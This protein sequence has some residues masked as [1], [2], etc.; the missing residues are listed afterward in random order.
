MAEIP[1]FMTKVDENTP[2]EVV[3][4]MLLAAQRAHLSSLENQVLLEDENALLK[5]KMYGKS[6]EKRNLKKNASLSH[7]MPMLQIFDEAMISTDDTSVDT[8]NEE[9]T[10]E[11]LSENTDLGSA[12]SNAFLSDPIDKNTQAS[13]RGRKR[14]P[15]HFIRENVIHD[16][17]DAEI[18]V[19]AVVSFL[20]LVRKSLN[21]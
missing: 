14:L 3:F 8:E 1:D 9:L 15:N 10:S 13:K 18:S 20:R 12:V 21:N 5:Q 17:S 6:S 7:T 16:L 2:P 4:A 19:P 11:P